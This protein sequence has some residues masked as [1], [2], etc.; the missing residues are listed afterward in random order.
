MRLA[1]NSLGQRVHKMPSF[2]GCRE[3]VGQY[4]RGAGAQMSLLPAGAAVVPQK[5]LGSPRQL[6]TRD[7]HFFHGALR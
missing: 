6:D 3:W 4:R 1:T 2:A 5:G 7:A